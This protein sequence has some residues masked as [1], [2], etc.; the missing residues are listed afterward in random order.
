MDALARLP[1]SKNGIVGGKR[2]RLLDVGARALGVGSR[3]V[4]L[5]DQRND[6]EIRVHG[7][8]GVRYGLCFDALRGIHDEH[9]AFASRET[10]RNLVRE[11]DVPGGIDEVETIRFAVVCR[12]VHTDSLAFNGDA[13]LPFDIHGIEQLLLHVT[14]GNGAR[15]LENAIG[16]GRF[17]M[18]D[19]SDDG[20]IPDMFAIDVHAWSVEPAFRLYVRDVTA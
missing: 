3:E 15:E 20:E 1:R 10:A 2:E 16:N 9:G 8:H 13:A 14:R 5:V 18:I 17:A 11:I 7:E 12:I 19:V 6:L 4:D